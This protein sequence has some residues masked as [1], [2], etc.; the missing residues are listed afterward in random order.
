M[1]L[2]R[3][4]ISV[5][6]KQRFSRKIICGR[7]Y[8]FGRHF[9]VS[10]RDNSIRIGDNVFADCR[11]YTVGTGSISIGSNTSIRY[12]TRIGAVERVEIGDNVIISNHVT[13]MDNNNHPVSPEKRLK[14]ISSGYGSELWSWKY[15][16]A[17]PVVI[18]NNV[19]IGEQARINKGV[20]V[21]EGSVIAAAAVVTK[22][23][24]PYAIVAGNPAIV[25]KEN[26]QH[27]SQIVV[28]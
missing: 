20:T 11:L 2:V 22:D 4:L 13:I 14:M 18:G 10:G 28:R 1:N 21:G 15:A 17:R 19:W 5:M 6:Q 3:K 27:G 7:Q 25:V 9:H 24:P 8:F 23:V 16:D 26:I 12:N